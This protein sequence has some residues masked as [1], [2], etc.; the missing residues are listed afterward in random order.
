MNANEKRRG[1]WVH[2]ALIVCF[3]AVLTVLLIWFLAFVLSDVG[4]IYGLDALEKEM[5]R[6]NAQIRDQKEI[7]QILRSSTDSSQETMDQL[8]AIHKLSLEK[9]V[10]P[11]EA[12][13]Q[14]LA[15]EHVAR[16]HRGNS[17]AVGHLDAGGVGVEEDVQQ[18]LRG[19][20]IGQAARPGAVAAGL[21]PT[22]VHQASFAGERDAAGAGSPDADANL[23]I[24]TKHP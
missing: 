19:S 17:L 22:L 11:T 5:V 7:Q 23:I 13:Q 3:A 4:R 21:A 18:R 6:L 10:R 24:R 14:A 2:R 12:E 8:V 1:P 16:F 15:G 9:G 20:H